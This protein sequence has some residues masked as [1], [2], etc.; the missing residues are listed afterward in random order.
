MSQQQTVANLSQQLE[1]IRQALN[2]FEITSKAMDQQVGPTAATGLAAVVKS[3]K[4]SI[5][6]YFNRFPELFFGKNTT[7]K[8][9]KASNPLDYGIAY[10]S[11]LLASLDL[12]S[13]IHTLSNLSKNMSGKGFDPHENPPPN[14][15]KWK[16]QKVAYDIQTSIDI[17]ESLYAT[18]SDPSTAII[19]LLSEINPNLTRLGSDNYLGSS[20]VRKMYPQVDQFNN[21]V[22]DTLK[23]YSNIGTISNTDKN[24]INSILKKVTLLRQVCVLLQGLSSPASLVTF[25]ESALPASTFAAID[26]LGV[27]NININS[28]TRT[29]ASIENT[30]R[31]IDQI[32]SFIVN[33][34]RYLQQLI[35]ICLVLVKIFKVIVN[36]FKVMPLPNMY[37]TSG[38]TTT[39][40]NT[41]NKLDEYTKDTINLLN[42]IN[43]FIA[44]IIGLIQG[45][46][47]AIDQITANLD[48]VLVNLKSCTRGND[49]N[50]QAISNL[51]NNLNNIKQANQSLKDFAQ[52]YQA[53]K[54]NMNNT[55]YGYTIQILTEEVTDKQVL[56]TTI[57]RR[58]GIAINSANIEVVKTDYTFASDDSV[59]QNEVKLLLAQKGLIKSSLSALTNQETDIVNESMNALQDNTITMDDIPI[60]SPDSEID[61]PDNEDDN[62]GLGINAF[63]NK[64][65]GGRKMRKKVR[66]IMNQSKQKLNSDLQNVKK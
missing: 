46:A 26:K 42:E 58:Y 9:S 66:K 24:T 17:F 21:F 4:R 23:K 8:G 53:K 56:K 43:L 12:C 14:D 13:I 33:Y 37:T 5:K 45:V 20:D 25:A 39:F 60:D 62:K 63:F 15:P 7:K 44:I 34:I 40:A 11:A 19:S 52:N 2:Q 31:Q 65:K 1:K 54:S 51:E 59:I 64:Q 10:L 36:F 22:T 18:T 3:L 57:P 55:Y 47:S 61:A 50:S 30:T 49:A 29:I 32:L 27:N 41:T 48:Q 35:K 16:I 28:L 38:V 6:S